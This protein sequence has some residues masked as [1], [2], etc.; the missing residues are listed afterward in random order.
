[1]A[2][3]SIYFIVGPMLVC[4]LCT[5]GFL[6]WKEENAPEKLW[7]PQDSAQVRDAHWVSRTFTLTTRFET[8]LFSSR[9]PGGNVLTSEVLLSV[10]ESSVFAGVERKRLDRYNA[11][12]G[13]TSWPAGGL[14]V[15]SRPEEM[16]KISA[17]GTSKIGRN[18][19]LIF[20]QEFLVVSAQYALDILSDDSKG[21]IPFLVYVFNG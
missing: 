2:R 6:R 7:I 8:V 17:H 3:K 18:N 4:G 15:A 1:V 10:S 19:I 14:H 11:R 16:F 12:P 13:E 5:L 20:C 9:T 21:F